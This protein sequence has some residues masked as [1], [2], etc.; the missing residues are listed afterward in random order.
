MNLIRRHRTLGLGAL[1]LATTGLLL[2][3]ACGDDGASASDG[4]L[5]VEIVSPDDGATVGSS[6]EMDLDPSVPVGE[7]DTGR[8]HIHVYYDGNT[9]EGEYSIVYGTTLTVDGLSPGEHTLE[10]AIANADHSLTDA[11]DE[12]TLVVGEGGSVSEAPSEAPSDLGY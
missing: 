10:A 6:F 9:A 5:S 12:I 1:G 3:A 11:S 7:P 2:L 8:H 4:P